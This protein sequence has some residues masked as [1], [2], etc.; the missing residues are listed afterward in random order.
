MDTEVKV[1]AISWPREEN[2]PAASVGTRTRDFL[3]T[4]LTPPLSDPRVAC[5]S[6]IMKITCAKSNQS[7]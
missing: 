7:G 2:Y 1:S 4:S 5:F 6:L 3:I